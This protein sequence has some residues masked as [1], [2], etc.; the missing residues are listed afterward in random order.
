MQWSIAAGTLQLPKRPKLKISLSSLTLSW[1][2]RVILQALIC[3][4]I[5]HPLF[6]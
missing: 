6:L 3:Y 2:D 1:G 5:F 4:V